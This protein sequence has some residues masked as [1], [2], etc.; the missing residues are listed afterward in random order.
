MFGI[1]SI[2]RNNSKINVISKDNLTDAD[3]SSP[4]ESDE[5]M[6]ITK[7]G[8]VSDTI[9]KIGCYKINPSTPNGNLFTFDILLLLSSILIILEIII[10][11]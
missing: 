4:G 11:F 7:F 9:W 6:K 8:A 1:T 10:C 2:T 3:C 5:D